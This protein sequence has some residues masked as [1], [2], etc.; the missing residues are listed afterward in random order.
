[1]RLRRPGLG[2]KGQFGGR[3]P[4]PCRFPTPGALLVSTPMEWWTPRP[5]VLGFSEPPPPIPTG[6][7]SR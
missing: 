4:K 1:M 2:R 3:R 6:A 5:R 7:P